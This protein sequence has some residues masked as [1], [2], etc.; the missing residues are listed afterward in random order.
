M[1]YYTFLY[2]SRDR[3]HKVFNARIN[4]INFRRR[5]IRCTRFLCAS[6]KRCQRQNVICLNCRDGYNFRILRVMSYDLRCTCELVPGAYAVDVPRPRF[7]LVRPNI[8]YSKMLYNGTALWGPDVT[9]QNAKSRFLR[10]TRR[11][12][13][14]N[15]ITITIFDTFY[16]NSSIR[17]PK[18]NVAGLIV[19]ISMRHF[20]QQFFSNKIITRCPEDNIIK[21]TRQT[22]ISNLI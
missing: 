7:A 3:H 14:T 8:D 9:V 16:W 6:R 19:L 5:R 20:S 21:D 18:N 15:R 10:H 4:S 17:V 1:R 11:A 13:Q 2:K 12:K 22:K